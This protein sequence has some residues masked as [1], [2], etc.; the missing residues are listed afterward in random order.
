MKKILV[1]LISEQHIPNLLSIHHINPDILVLI[2]TPFM[3]RRKAGENL[4]KALRLGNLHF[5]DS[6]LIVR[7][8]EQ[9]DSVYAMRALLQDLK[10]ELEKDYADCGVE[11]HVNVSGGLKTMSIG[12]FLSFEEV[13]DAR[14]WYIENRKPDVLLQLNSQHSHSKHINYRPTTREFMAGYDFTIENKDSSLTKNRAMAEKL[15]SCARIFAQYE[16]SVVSMSHIRRDE[17]RKRGGLLEAS[18][19]VCQSQE[20]REAL[21]DN[22]DLSQKLSKDAMKFLTGE[23]LEVF[24]MGLLAKRQEALAMWDVNMGISLKQG[25]VRNEYDVCYLRHYNFSSIECKTGNQRDDDITEILYKVK[26]TTEQFRAL[27]VRPYLAMTSEHLLSDDKIKEKFAK[28]ADAYNIT[29]LSRYDIQELARNPNDID[30]IK[31]KLQL[32]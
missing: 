8:F 3:K 21:Q 14:L 22:F 31:R 10:A 26:T 11:W 2:E 28:R 24:F 1:C 30:L 4:Q 5:N 18:D 16:H 12:A 19:I 9:E 7:S 25:N 20:A 29:L 27:R 6:T 17:S 23:W 32:R 15:W 13:R